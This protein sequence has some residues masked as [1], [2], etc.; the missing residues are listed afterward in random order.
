MARAIIFTLLKFL[1]SG[2]FGPSAWILLLQPP[3]KPGTGPCRNRALPGRLW[4]VQEYPQRDT[5][6][7]PLHPIEGYDKRAGKM[8][9]SAVPGAGWWDRSLDPFGR[10]GARP[11]RQRPLIALRIDRWPEAW[12]RREPIPG[13]LPVDCVSQVEGWLDA[14]RRS[15]GPAFRRSGDRAPP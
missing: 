5:L 13:S 15:G 14:I 11:I 8:G 7:P 3:G 6:L 2:E 1:W 9:R 4:S 12:C 10:P